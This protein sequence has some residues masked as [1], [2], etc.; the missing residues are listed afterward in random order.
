MQQ[1]YKEWSSAQ[2]C[3][4]LD[5]LP[6]LATMEEF[7]MFMCDENI[8][9]SKIPETNSKKPR[10][11]SLSPLHHLC[12]PFW[13]KDHPDND[14][15]RERHASVRIDKE[16]CRG[17]QKITTCVIQMPTWST[18]TG[19][20]RVSSRNWNSMKP[21]M[22]QMTSVRLLVTK[23]KSDGAGIPVVDNV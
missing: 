3:D 8:R 14:A 7:N 16:R 22:R 13:I 17:G 1:M 9:I 2:D 21:H 15:I 12:F 6:P 18:G 11:P 10:V 23:P 20:E 5:R 4:F 19:N